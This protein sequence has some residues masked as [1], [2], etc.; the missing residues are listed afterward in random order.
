MRR[1]RA[2]EHVSVATKFRSQDASETFD[3][4]QVFPDSH[5]LRCALRAIR[6]LANQPAVGSLYVFQGFRV[7]RGQQFG[8][9]NAE[10]H[11]NL[12]VF[13]D[14]V[15]P[16]PTHLEVLGWVCGSRA[17][18]VAHGFDAITIPPKPSRL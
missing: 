11:K 17:F 5:R 4:S 7:L 14:G 10:G 2:A 15:P 12:A 6:V 3:D 16:S 8:K 9:W 1:R 13:S 18:P